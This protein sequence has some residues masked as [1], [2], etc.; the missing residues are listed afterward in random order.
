MAKAGR[1]EE[2]GFHRPTQTDANAARAVSNPGKPTEAANGPELDD[3]LAKLDKVLSDK[4][5]APGLATTKAPL[6]A[7]ADATDEDVVP[8]P[9]AGKQLGLFDSG[10]DKP[11]T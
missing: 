7:R 6:W 5:A 2:L 3:I 11:A 10:K 4:P 8:K 1:L 9:D